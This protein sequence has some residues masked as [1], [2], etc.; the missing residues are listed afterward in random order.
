MDAAVTWNNFMAR[1]TSDIMALIAAH[2]D[3]CQGY[4]LQT[5][6]LR[7]FLFSELAPDGSLATL[8]LPA[9]ILSLSEF[10]IFPGALA[11]AR[12][13]RTLLYARI[14]EESNEGSGAQGS[15]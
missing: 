4:E 8:P 15:K 11:T 9:L 2:P 12:K 7:G 3:V 13:S 10:G 6:A 14:V 1:P 5:A